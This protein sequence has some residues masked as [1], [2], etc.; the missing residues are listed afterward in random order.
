MVKKDLGKVDERELKVFDIC[1]EY[2]EIGSQSFYVETYSG[3]RM[4]GSDREGLEE[5]IRE[6]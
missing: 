2:P 6:P 3:S 4:D 5:A 1:E